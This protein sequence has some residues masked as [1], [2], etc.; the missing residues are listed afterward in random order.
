MVYRLHE[1]VIAQDWVARGLDV[2]VE[3]GVVC[4]DENRLRRNFLAARTHIINNHAVAAVGNKAHGLPLVKL[5]NHDVLRVHGVR[6][7]PLLVVIQSLSRVGRGA[8]GEQFRLFA[9]VITLA[10]LRVCVL[11]GAH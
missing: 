2:A 4:V 10:N 6:P 8:V 9:V 5:C 7:L 1:V 3:F 11:G